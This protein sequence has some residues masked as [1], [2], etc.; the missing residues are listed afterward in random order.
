MGIIL[1]K[2]RHNKIRCISGFE[3]SLLADAHA[4]PFANDEFDLVVCCSYTYYP[5]KAVEEIFRVLKTVVLFM[6]KFHFYRVFMKVFLI[7][8]LYEWTVCFK[9]F[10]IKKL[11][12]LGSFTSLNWSIR[13]VLRSIGLGMIG[14]FYF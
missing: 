8:T 12:S 9:D 13:D 6:V 10:Q 14:K 11:Y 3:N 2:A 4:I 1:S 7:F 5:S